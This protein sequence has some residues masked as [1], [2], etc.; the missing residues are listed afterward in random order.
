M[1]CWGEKIRE[2][3]PKNC[4]KWKKGRTFK[5]SK[6]D[7]QDRKGEDRKMIEK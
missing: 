7:D 3:E 5:E 6:Y 4:E 2:N 1:V